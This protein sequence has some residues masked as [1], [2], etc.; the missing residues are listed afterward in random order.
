[1]LI[2]LPTALPGNDRRAAVAGAAA[3][4]TAVAMQ[5]APAQAGEGAKYGT[6]DPQTCASAKEPAKGA[7]SAELA[8]KYVI[9]QK[10]EVAHTQGFIYLLE[11]VTVEI[12]KGVPL[13]ELS[14][15]ARPTDGDPDGVVYPIRG[16]LKEYQCAVASD[17]GALG[18]RY[19]NIG[20]NCNVYDEPKATGTCYRTTFGDWHCSMSDLNSRQIPNQPPP[21]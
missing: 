21:K 17:G 16:S 11:N 19:N 18:P 10:E 4:L 7:I 1:M 9:C 6:R 20:K 5:T 15:G 8:R 14:R 12:G 2:G 13:L 3:L